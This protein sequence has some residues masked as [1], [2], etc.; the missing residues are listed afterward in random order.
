MSKKTF[1]AGIEET[2]NPATAF[3]TVPD[4]EK[5][6]EDLPPKPETKSV[7]VNLLFRPTTKRNIEKLATMDQ[8]SL[9]D[10]INTAMEQYIQTR[11]KDL[12]KYDRIFEEDK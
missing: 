4:P 1:K 8:T 6:P 2:V 9:N 10:L 7:R 12:E 11:S 5:T 3:I